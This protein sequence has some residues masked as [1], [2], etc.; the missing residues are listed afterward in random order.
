MSQ[1]EFISHDRYPQDPYVM[2][3]VV[4]CLEG[5]HRVVFIRKKMKNGGM[6]W[7]V[8]TAGVKQNGETK[9]LKAYASDSNFLREDI[10][11]FLEARGWEAG[12]GR[13]LAEPKDEPIPF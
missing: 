4:L 13:S 5:K 7:D 8:I 2:E 9:Y 10:M 3:S 1:F 12:K 11:N 6:F